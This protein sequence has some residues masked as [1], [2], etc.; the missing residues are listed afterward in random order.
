MLVHFAYLEGRGVRTV[1]ASSIPTTKSV[2]IKL[3]L[4]DSPPSIGKILV[5]VNPNSGAGKGIPTFY[6]KVA[7]QLKKN[8]IQYELVITSEFL[9]TRN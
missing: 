5:F 9:M 2:S 1:V 3:F 4:A 7:S 8:N 6:S